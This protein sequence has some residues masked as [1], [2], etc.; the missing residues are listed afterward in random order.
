MAFRLIRRLAV[1]PWSEFRAQQLGGEDHLGWTADTYKL[2][3]LSSGLMVNTEI[4]RVHGSKA[5]PKKI[6]PSWTPPHVR[7]AKVGEAPVL[8][9]MNL[10]DFDARGMLAE[11]NGPPIIL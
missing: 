4:T 3:E 6:T 11:V 8:E 7:A 9:K 1:E 10:S 5:K 2:T